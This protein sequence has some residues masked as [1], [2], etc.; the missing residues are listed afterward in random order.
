MRVEK[1]NEKINIRWTRNKSMREKTQKAQSA[2]NILLITQYILL[3]H[4]L[5]KI[6]I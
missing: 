3:A 4:P 5:V 1:K 2:G 6:K